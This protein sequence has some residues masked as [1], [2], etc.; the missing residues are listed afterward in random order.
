MAS[1]HVPTTL[2]L[3]ATTG[4]DPSRLQVTSF[5]TT[6]TK[7]SMTLPIVRYLVQSKFK[8]I[9]IKIVVKM[10][11]S[12]KWWDEW[13]SWLRR[14]WTESC[15]RS[16]VRGGWRRYILYVGAYVLLG[17]MYV[18]RYINLYIWCIHDMW[19]SNRRCT[20]YL[21]SSRHLRNTNGHTIHTYVGRS[22]G[23]RPPSL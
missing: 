18:C 12:M 8:M 3:A 11:M 13:R 10:K 5:W 7:L 1:P 20:Y 14:R 15:A 19:Y 21:S 17:C 2:H 9:K 16:L 22:M 6:A 23:Q 4:L